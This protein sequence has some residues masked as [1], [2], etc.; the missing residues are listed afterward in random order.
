MTDGKIIAGCRSGR[1]S[2]KLSPATAAG[3]G[4]FTDDLMKVED[5]K[6]GYCTQFLV[7]KNDGASVT[8]CAPS[9]SPTATAWWSSRMTRSSTAMCTPPTRA[10][11]SAMRIKYGYLTNFKIENM[12]EQFLARQKQGKGLEKQ[13]AGRAEK[14]DSEFTYA[15]VDPER[16]VRL[17]GRGRRRGPEGRA[18][19]TWVLTLSS[20]AARR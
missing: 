12:H 10:R 11:S 9:W 7:H 17:C 2:A 13:A 4:V 5:I 8:S 19:P 6:N 20:A 3:K 18:L 16:D 14:T 1:Q 15:A